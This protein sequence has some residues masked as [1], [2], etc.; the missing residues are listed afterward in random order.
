MKCGT[1]TFGKFKKIKCIQN[2][3]IHQKNYQAEEHT[4]APNLKFI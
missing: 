3:H 2:N 4:K 1:K